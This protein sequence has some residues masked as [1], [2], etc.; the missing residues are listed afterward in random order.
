M[1]RVAGYFLILSEGRYFSFRGNMYDKFAEP[2]PEFSHPRYVPLVCFISN[3]N[4]NI[5][6]IGLGKRGV[7]AGTDLRRLN[8]ED[9]FELKKPISA[10][11]IANTTGSRVRSHIINKINSGGL[12]SPK[13]FEEF[14]SAFLKKATDTIPLLDKYSKA[15]QL[16][17]SKLSKDAKKSLAEQKE[18]VLTAMNIAGIDRD[19][20]QGWDYDEAEKPISFLDGIAQ[21][22]LR[23]DSMIINDLSNIPGFDLIKSTRYSSSVFENSKT[24]LTVLLANRLPLEELLGTDLIYF[25]EDFRCFIMV[26]YKTMEKERDKFIFR[27]PNLQFSEEI[28]RM[29]SIIQS[30]KSTNG[31]GFIHDYRFNE[32]PFFVK[33]CPRLEFDPDNVGLSTGMYIPLDYIKMLE[34]DKC[35]EG[36]RGGKAI[37]Y[38][39]VGRY[40][41][42]TGFKTIIE[43]GWIGTNQ[44]QSLLIEKM[45]RDILENGKAAVLAIKKK[46]ENDFLSKQFERNEDESDDFENLPF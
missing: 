44:N 42:N 40:L 46:L 39:N 32:N 36:E 33:I 13:C 25:N 34:K 27:L 37:S 6:H 22:R 14:L 3:E 45:I 7:R 20:A 26:Q 15:R 8:I 19:N 12:F 24:R 5:T 10:I 43:G 21:V 31:N 28:S 30:L 23:E 11:G 29:D 9:I 38:D 17:I 41:D 18:A 35:I 2:I 1:S 16:R 4:G